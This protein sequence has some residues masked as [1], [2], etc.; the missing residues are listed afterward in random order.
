MTDTHAPSGKVQARHEQAMSVFL[1]AVELGEDERSEYLTRACGNDAALR[2][3]VEELL[4]IDRGLAAEGST[5]HAA[6]A[7]DSETIPCGPDYSGNP[8]T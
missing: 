6:L 4:G 8:C 3:E 2:T 1:H 7:F 5:S